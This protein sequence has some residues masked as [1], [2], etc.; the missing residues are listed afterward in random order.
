LETTDYQY[1]YDV[2]VNAHGKRHIIDRGTVLVKNNQY[3]IKKEQ[4]HLLD[5]PG[6][7]EV[8]VEL[9]SKKQAIDFMI[10]E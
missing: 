1:T 6:I 7:Q 9:S 2:S 8:V 10:G 3:Y 5:V 4:F